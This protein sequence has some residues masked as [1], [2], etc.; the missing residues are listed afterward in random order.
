MSSDKDSDNE[1]DKPQKPS[2][3]F[4]QKISRKRQEYRDWKEWRYERHCVDEKSN[5]HRLSQTKCCKCCC[6]LCCGCCNLVKFILIV[7]NVLFFICG[8]CLMGVGAYGVFRFDM[9]AGFLGFLS[10][11]TGVIGAGSVF[12]AF[13]GIQGARLRRKEG[14]TEC[15]QFFL[16]LYVFGIAGVIFLELAAVLFLT[17]WCTNRVDELSAVLGDNVGETINYNLGNNLANCSF[18]D[19]CP[20]VAGFED[21]EVSPGVWQLPEENQSWLAI[22]VH[23]YDKPEKEEE[24]APA[25]APFSFGPSPASNF[26]NSSSTP[27]PIATITG[28]APSSN[29]R[30]DDFQSLRKV[31]LIGNRQMCTMFE[32]VQTKENCADFYTYDQAVRAYLWKMMQPLQI[33]LIVVVSVEFVGF[34]SAWFS[35][36]WCCGAGSMKI[37]IDDSDDDEHEWAENEHHGKYELDVFCFVF[38]VFAFQFDYFRVVFINVFYLFIFFTIL[39]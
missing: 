36:L 22:C 39:K 27:S 3:S 7:I 25:P 23:V 30:S 35:L 16:L 8:L 38:C 26:S 2:E 10:L 29:T 1:D 28:L 31:D 33:F 32:S 6:C 4:L 13:L 20:N 18:N 11:I 37:D 9:G 24:G 12:F 34:V 5:C 14:A 15:G 19:C 21:Y 17:F